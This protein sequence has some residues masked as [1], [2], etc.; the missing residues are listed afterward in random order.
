MIFSFIVMIVGF[1][2]ATPFSLLLTIPAYGLADR[3]S[4]S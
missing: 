2:F 1:T 4:I 3:V